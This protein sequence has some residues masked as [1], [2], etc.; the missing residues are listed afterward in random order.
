[1]NEGTVGLLGPRAALEV[2]VRR[3]VSVFAKNMK[4][5][6]IPHHDDCIETR[7][8]CDAEDKRCEGGKVRTLVELE[9]SLKP[10]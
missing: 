8:S 1:M 5:W 9:R 2:K 7:A 6:K 4:P 10:M 3:T